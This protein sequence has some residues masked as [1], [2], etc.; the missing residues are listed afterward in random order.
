[1]KKG[2]I[3]DPKVNIIYVYDEGELTTRGGFKA[4]KMGIIVDGG[5]VLVSRGSKPSGDLTA[6][7]KTSDAA[8]APSIHVKRG[9]LQIQNG[10][11]VI[12]TN[13][14]LVEEGGVPP[15]GAAAT[16]ARLSTLS[17]AP[18]GAGQIA[19]I[20]GA[21]TVKSGEVSLG[22]VNGAIGAYY[23]TL[24]V[25]SKVK[26]LGGTFNTDVSISD[27]A[28]ADKIVT[29]STIEFGPAMK[30]KVRELGGVATSGMS[31][32]IFEAESGLAT[33]TVPANLADYTVT[34]SNYLTNGKKIGIKKN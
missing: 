11:K 13:G 21:L 1:V 5:D 10:E 14:V 25:T 9:T 27:T 33:Q 16:N 22:E 31:W 17:I 34:T 4:N 15:I 29:K 24:S 18:G 32:D 8:D 30:I 7:G 12:A 28:K 26:F 3:T 23:S 19:T 20:E 6:T 2:V